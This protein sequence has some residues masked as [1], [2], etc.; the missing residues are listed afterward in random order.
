[1]STENSSDHYNYVQKTVNN[2]IYVHVRFR[3]NDSYVHVMFR[4]ETQN[5]MDVDD[6]FFLTF[7]EQA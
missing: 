1:M 4:C 3:K 2:V 5:A 7:S 6:I